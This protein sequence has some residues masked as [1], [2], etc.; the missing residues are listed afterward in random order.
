MAEGDAARGGHEPDPERD[1]TKKIRR[2]GMGMRRAGEDLLND[3]EGIH[4]GLGILE[5]VVAAA[6]AGTV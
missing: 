4:F 6:R 5:K 3:Y 2:E 1:I